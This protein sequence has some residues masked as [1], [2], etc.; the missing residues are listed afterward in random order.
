LTIASWGVPAF[1]L[2][3]YGSVSMLSLITAVMLTVMLGVWPFLTGRRLTQ[4]R[5]EHAMMCVECRSLA[6]PAEQAL[7]FCLRCGSTKKAVPMTT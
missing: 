3:S 6:W 2:A 1:E 4:G 7:G 5:I